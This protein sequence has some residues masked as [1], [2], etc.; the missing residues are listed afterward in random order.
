MSAPAKPK[1]APEAPTL[2]TAGFHPMLANPP[3]TPLAP[4]DYAAEDA[5]LAQFKATA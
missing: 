2:S 3:A 5:A 4:F 1:I